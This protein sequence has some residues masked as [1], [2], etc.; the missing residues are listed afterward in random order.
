MII[1]KHRP[2]SIKLLE[3][4]LKDFKKSRILSPLFAIF[5]HFLVVI[6]GNLYFIL[7]IVLSIITTS[8]AVFITQ[9][10][11]NRYK[12]IVKKILIG[13]KYITFVTISEEHFII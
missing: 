6:A 11:I 2:T 13:E 9:N 8:A 5:I 3:N 4:D 10:A 12:K 7:M 1:F